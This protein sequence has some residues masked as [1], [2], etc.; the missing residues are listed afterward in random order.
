MIIEKLKGEKMSILDKL[1]EA[2]IEVEK[3]FDNLFDYSEEENQINKKIDK[4]IN[5]ENINNL[6][7]EVIENN[8]EKDD[9]K[10]IEESE[11]E[12][13]ENNL[14]KKDNLNLKDK[15]EEL[16]E[17]IKEVLIMINEVDEMGYDELRK[18]LELYG[19]IVE[20]N[21]QNEIF[22]S[23]DKTKP[24]KVTLKDLKQFLIKERINE[25]EY[26]PK[27][28][29]LEKVKEKYENL[30]KNKIFKINHFPSIKTI[31]K[32][33]KMIDEYRQANKKVT[34]EVTEDNLKN[35]QMYDTAV[36][37]V[38]KK[39]MMLE[40][41]KEI[42]NTI[43]KNQKQ[44]NEIE[45]ENKK[46]S[47]QEE[48]EKITQELQQEDS[49]IDKYSGLSKKYLENNNF[50]N[51]QIIN[52]IDADNKFKEVV[53]KILDAKEYEEV[54]NINM[55]INEIN[56]KAKNKIS[57]VAVLNLADEVI[58]KLEETLEKA[59][60]LKKEIENEL[61]SPKTKFI[62]EISQ[63]ERNLEKNEQN[64]K[65]IVKGIKKIDT[66]IDEKSSNEEKKE[67]KN[68]KKIKRG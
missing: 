22:A 28:L 4:V 39:L 44:I 7:E 53:K 50:F 29:E 41:K 56:E 60:K 68:V 57:L 65:K 8:L 67:K 5:D 49:M 64:N 36:T 52:N 6:Q 42:K 18:K 40:K 27:I 9:K 15:I 46:V 17:E 23:K 30:S 58:E 3:S 33:R 11:D 13:I 43:D 61:I 32:V 24:K 59:E 21:S 31:I 20:K 38:N 2:K 26:N 16:G 19:Y 62:N 14:N 25:A 48:N 47:L 10:K 66:I 54:K 63:L 45:D 55:E 34:F 1:K 12:N 51:S 35:K 37:L